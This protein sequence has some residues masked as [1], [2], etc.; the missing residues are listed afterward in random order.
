MSGGGL[1]ISVVG[2]IWGA[3][4]LAVVAAM[5]ILA[6]RKK[7][8][9]GIIV[10]VIVGLLFL[11][12]F[13]GVTGAYLGMNRATH[14]RTEAELAIQVA[15][16]E[17]A[18]ALQIAGTEAERAMQ[19]AGTEAERAMQVAQGD[20]A[21]S[22]TTVELPASERD[23]GNHHVAMR[24]QSK[25]DTSTQHRKSALGSSVS[26]LP[27]LGQITVAAL[28]AVLIVLAYLFVDAG[29][30]DRYTWPRRIAWAV[31]FTAVCLLLSQS[32]LLL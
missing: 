24:S 29:K 26:C 6:F 23:T 25:C 3:C 28:L 10:G 15:R 20:E 32:D 27:I 21:Y 16:T 30:H 19:I 4:L 31:A 2:L 11:F 22:V 1:G 8:A 14:A 9:A 7:G 13:L 17:A 12:V 5:L 18:R